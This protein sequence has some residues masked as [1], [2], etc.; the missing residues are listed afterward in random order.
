MSKVPMLA[1][2]RVRDAIAARLHVGW[3][4]LHPDERAHE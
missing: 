2:D 4:D 3:L 1:A